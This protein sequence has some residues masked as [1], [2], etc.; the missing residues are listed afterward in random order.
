MNILKNKYFIL[1]NLFLVLISVPITLFFIK[2]QQEV[3]SR[4]APSSKLYFQ[5]SSPNTS[6]RCASFTVD[7]MLDPGQ[8]IVSIV[9]LGITYDST[10]LDLISIVESTIFSSVVKAQDLKPGSGTMSVSVG[11][12][13]IKAAQTITKVATLTFKPLIQGT[14][15]IK[16]DTTLTKAFS[17]STSDSPTENVL[18]TT[19]PASAA[20]NTNACTTGQ[21]VSI[22]ESPTPTVAPTTISAN[23]PPVCTEFSVTPQNQGTAPFAVQ[24]SA[25]GND[26]DG[27]VTKATF[28]YGDG[29]AE[30]ITENMNLQ[31]VTVQK[32]HTYQNA[33]SYSATAT[34][35][36]DKSAISQACTLTITV[37]ASSGD[38]ATPTATLTP[39]ETIAP[40]GNFSS[41]LGIMGGVIL[42]IV[43]V[44]LLFAL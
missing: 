22:T 12:D 38:T 1:G 23:E 18:S 19:T 20:I 40:T 28:V 3:R 36:D 41:A 10:K 27:T 21:S 14:A 6:T 15:D 25:K 16:F 8:N 11:T 5:P 37:S 32:D 2:K 44:A 34:F 35:T 30:D 33:G 17:L 42:T 31:S 7:V 13:V 24:F 29:N 39:I 9:D 26:T 43:G 4:A